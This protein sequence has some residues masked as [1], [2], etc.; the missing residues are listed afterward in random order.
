[1][2]ERYR[3]DY[4]GEYV[5]T[6]INWSGGIKQENREWIS[7]PI[8]NQHISGRAAVLGSSIHRNAVDSTFNIKLIE[9]HHGGL[10]GQ[11]RLQT[12]GCDDI[13]KEIQCD[14]FVETNSDALQQLGAS[15]YNN[16]TTVYTSSRNCIVF[17]GQYYLIPYNP[18][19][20]SGAAAAYLAAFDGH[21]E[22]F[23]VGVDGTDDSGNEHGRFV[24]D[25]NSIIRAYPGTKFHLVTDRPATPNAW[26][27]NSNFSAMNYRDFILYCDIG[28]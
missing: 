27:Q 5:I 2:I 17:P 3:K 8:E 23:L 22:I 26:L 12:Y 4:E 28:V 16:T 14:F 20:T 25:M 1:M 10:L 15:G 7:N 9:S 19:I 21:E 24:N 13:W 6:S 18:T 11:D